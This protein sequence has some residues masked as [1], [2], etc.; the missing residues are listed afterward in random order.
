[1]TVIVRPSLP[2]PVLSS[3][4]T[5][6][7]TAHDINRNLGV[8]RYICS[9]FLSNSDVAL[10]QLI[11]DLAWKRIYNDPMPYRVVSRL[12][13]GGYRDECSP[14]DLPEA[15][16]ISLMRARQTR[17]RHYILDDIGRLVDIVNPCHQR[18]V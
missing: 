14:A 3:T 10:T 18:V 15:I 9:R 11:E 8:I 12:E 2:I 6:S 4:L 13:F 16:S 5:C 7:D 17:L 1:M